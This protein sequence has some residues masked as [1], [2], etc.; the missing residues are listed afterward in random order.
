MRAEFPFPRNPVPVIWR[1]LRVRL[2]GLQGGH[3]GADIH[4][5]RANAL[6]TLSRLLLDCADGI[7]LCLCTFRGGDARNAI[8]REATAL[9]AIPAAEI[10]SATSTLWALVDALRAEYASTEPGLAVAIEECPAPATAL[11]EP[12]SR[13][14]LTFLRAGPIGVI[15]TIAAPDGAVETS[16]NLAIVSLEETGVATVQYL[17]RSVVESAKWDV[18]GTL[19]SLARLAGGNLEAQGDYPGWQPATGSSLVPLFSAAC[20]RVLGQPA[21]T[22]VVH[23]GLEC[24]ILKAIKPSLDCI[25]IG[26]RIESMHSPEERVEVASVAA[27]YRIL[28]ST[29]EAMPAA[30]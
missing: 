22:A 21:R 3:S 29:L 17:A 18:F 19:A 11:S 28:T 15:R 27:F 8:P 23:G 4:R 6:R 24:G 2:H 14:F 16:N 5:G 12:S 7:P 30:S 26:P 10:S 1:G 25:S 9:V 20:A 13:A